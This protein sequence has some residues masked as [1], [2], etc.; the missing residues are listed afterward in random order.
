MDRKFRGIPILPDGA[1]DESLEELYE[2]APCGYVSTTSD[3]RIIKANRT[4]SE[5]TGYEQ[6][7]LTAGMRFLDL[8]TVGGKIFYETHFALLLA[9][10]GQVDEIA[11]DMACKGGR[12]VPTLVTARQ[13]RNAAGEPILNRLTVFNAT[14]RRTYERELLSARKRAEE[15]AAELS[16]VNSEL[17][18]CNAELLRANDE[19]A[20]FAYAASHDLQEPLRAISLY[21]ELLADRHPKGTDEEAE[22]FMR[23]ILDGSRRMKMLIEDLLSFSRAQ[24]SDLVLR[25]AEME[26]VLDAALVN[27]RSSIEES[28]ATVTYDKLPKVTVD[29]ARIVHVFQNLLG[30][31]IKYRKPGAAPTVRIS[32]ARQS[33]PEWLFTVEDNGFGFEPRYAEQIFGLFKRLHGRDIPGTGIGLA[34][35]KKI[36]ES[37]GGRIWATS[38]VGVGSRFCF[39]IP[40]RIPS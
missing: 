8:L 37:H 35:C 18:Q 31:A 7:E 25:T 6:Q 4:F 14:E 2:S 29:A 39:T 33:S 36:I 13:K 9:M 30:N 23:Y 20:Q 21:T 3:G 15:S 24:G 19:L 32:A 34:L 11:L 38:A 1:L 5:W 26:S 16:R 28:G 10:H 22:T 12:V 40:D 17:K 27:L